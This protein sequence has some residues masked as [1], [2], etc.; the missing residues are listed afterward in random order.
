MKILD[1]P[2]VSNYWHLCR[3]W[4]EHQ[5][6]KLGD[7]IIAAMPKEATEQQVDNIFN[8]E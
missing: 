6:Q 7:R 4:F 8:A 1:L 2:R 3:R 5:F